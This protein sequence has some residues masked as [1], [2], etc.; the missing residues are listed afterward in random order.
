MFGQVRR[1]AH[2]SRN[3]SKQPC[4]GLIDQA[5]VT[6]SS[7]PASSTETNLTNPGTRA[8]GTSSAK[9]TCR[10]DNPASIAAFPAADASVNAE[11]TAAIYRAL[12]RAELNAPA[13]VKDSFIPV[14]NDFDAMR[15]IAKVLQAA[16][17][18]FLIVDPYMDEKALVVFAALASQG[19]TIRLLA[20]QHDAKPSLRPAV[21]AWRN[22]HGKARPVDARLAPAKSLHDRLLVVD[23]TS[24]WTL[25]QSLN[26]FAKRSPASIVKVDNETA[27][28]KIAAYE[29]IW[30][31]AA[32]V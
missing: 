18:N 2:K 3:A 29:A 8:C 25:T 31:A 4:K 22:Q 1:V 27:K 9:S 26:S 30:L 23:G 21:E 7:W 10:V 13:S 15:A 32:P 12:A 17:N 5:C 19:V 16:T 20:D 11:I 24:V 14:G 6:K 28:L